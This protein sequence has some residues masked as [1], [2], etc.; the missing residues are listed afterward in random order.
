MKKPTQKDL[1]KI[2][3]QA[4]PSKENELKETIQELEDQI[5]FITENK[6]EI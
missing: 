5:K 3:Q 1:I 4:E 6:Q 2:D